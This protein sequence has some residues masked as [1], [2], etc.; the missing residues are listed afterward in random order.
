MPEHKY[1]FNPQTLNF[2]RIRLSA[3]QRT[4]RLGLMLMPGLVVGLLGIFLVYQFV[5]SPKEALLR[6][7]NK[8]LLVQYELLNKRLEELDRVMA[9]VRR[10]D[11]NIYRVIF[12]ADP[13]PES[14]RRAGVGG[15]NRYKDLDGFASSD[16]VI[17]TR[18]RLDQ[19]SRQLVVQSRSLDEVAALVLRKQE[20]L[21]SIPAIQPIPNEDLTQTAGGY[22]MRIPPIHKIPKFHAGMDFTAKQGTPIY[23]TGD[24]RV[25]FADYAT[26][27]YGRHVVIDHGFGY[28]TLYAHLSELKVRNGQK[29]KR[30]DVIGLVG[31]TGLSAGPH[32]HYEVHKNGQPVDPAN[33]YFNDLTPEEYARMLELSRNA[34]QSLD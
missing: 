17:D 3:W 28:N 11:D 1:R 4:R 29:V 16:L 8:Q 23:A 33:Y 9:D 14:M 6:R 21:A 10:R 30:G 20:M 27:G 24:G 15:I 12:E 5:D 7:E 13:V 19:M 26:N 22:G 2:E 18:K 31:N 32:L 25:T 34:G